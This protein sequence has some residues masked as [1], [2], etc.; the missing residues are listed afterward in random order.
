MTC[1][2]KTTTVIDTFA[3]THTLLRCQISH[4]Y[5]LI[6][7]LILARATTKIFKNKLGVDI[8]Y[9]K[10]YF[11]IRING[12]TFIRVKRQ[13]REYLQYLSVFVTDTYCKSFEKVN[14]NL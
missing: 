13:V 1:Q 4:G 6:K 3:T 5:L 9:S 11:V 10:N 7:V 8:G 2:E 12:N 14:L